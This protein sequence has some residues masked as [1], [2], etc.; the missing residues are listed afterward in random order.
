MPENEHKNIIIPK[1]LQEDKLYVDINIRLFFCRNC[2]EYFKVKY[3]KDKLNQLNRQELLKEPERCS[4]CQSRWWKIWE[5]DRVQCQRCA[6]TIDQSKYTGNLPQAC[7]N[8]RKRK[9]LRKHFEKFLNYSKEIREKFM[10]EY[11][12]FMRK[13]PGKIVRFTPTGDLEVTKFR[14][15]ILEGDNEKIEERLR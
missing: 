7:P 10:E 12:E 11:R 1:R 5:K 8:C 14:K 4:K 2:K 15:S 3:F 9:Y 6:Y 13:N